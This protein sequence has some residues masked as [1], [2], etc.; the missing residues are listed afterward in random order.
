MSHV[1]QLIIK[2]ALPALL[3]L[4]ACNTTAE[5]DLMDYRLSNP[6]LVWYDE[7]AGD[8]INLTNWQFDI[9]GHGWG[10]NE[11]QYYT[12][13]P[14]NAYIDDGMLVIQA[15]SEPYKG[16]YFSSA[17][18]K[19]LGL[20][21]FQYGRIEARIKLPS[22]QGI[23]PAFWMLG[24]QFPTVGWPACGEIDIMEHI[25][26]EPKTVHG[27]VHGPGFNRGD[28]IGAS[29][30]VDEGSMADEF[31]IF[32]IEWLPGHIQWFVDGNLFHTVS[33]TSLPPE[34][35]WVFDQPFFLLLN[36]AVGGDWPGIP[37]STTQFPQQMLVDY[38]R[39][40]QIDD[41]AA[42]GKSALLMQETGIRVAMHIEEILVTVEDNG[43]PKATI[44][45][46][47]QFGD[48]IQGVRIKVR[49]SGGGFSATETTGKTGSDGWT[50]P[51][52]SPRVTQSGNVFLCIT[53][54]SKQGY[55]FDRDVSI[56]PCL[57]TYVDF[58]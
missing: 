38:V 56:T 41:P 9:G 26:R 51:F 40:Y 58:E 33:I 37:D 54:I 4:S 11:L 30:H 34:G 39:V 7:F 5:E 31:H 52:L 55:I 44:Q 47:D 20:Q 48:P 57:S 10:N 36:V 45:I 24:A 6:T 46:Q 21:E 18:L 25:G 43:H 3:L 1:P 16:S 15:L 42:F 19:T 13:K 32:A 53:E 2:M 12:N 28:G 29:Y 23:W 27:T 14:D 22:G 49:W 35:R 17:R 8:D 50:S